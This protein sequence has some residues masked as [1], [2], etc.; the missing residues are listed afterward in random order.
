MTWLP[1]AELRAAG[2]E[3]FKR[4]QPFVMANGQHVTRH[5]GVAVIECGEFKT[6]DEVVL[7]SRKR[8]LVGAGPIPAASA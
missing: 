4:D 8:R 6:V 3:T 1:E 2:V 7:D 5:V